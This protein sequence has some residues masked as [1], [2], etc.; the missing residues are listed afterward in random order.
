M[1]VT[2]QALREALTR[3]VPLAGEPGPDG[4]PPQ[5]DAALLRGYL[6]QRRFEVDPFGV[7]LSGFEIVGELAAEATDVV[8]PVGFER[9][10]FSHPL[11]LSGSSLHSLALVGCD[12]P[13]LVGNGLRLRRDLILS[14]SRISGEVATSASISYPGAVW[15][16]E[17]EIG[18]R[19]VAAGTMIAPPTGRAL[20]ADGVRVRGAV[21][22]IQDFAAT[23]EVR[24]LSSRLGSLDISGARFD[25]RDGWALNLT[26]TQLEGNLLLLRDTTG[27]ATRL[28]GWLDL[29]DAHVGGQLIV[30]DASFAVPQRISGSF[31][32]HL[33]DRGH[34]C[35]VAPRLAVD[36]AVVLS[37]QTRLDGGADLSL[38]RMS[39]LRVA[40][41][42]RLSAA[43]SEALDLSRATIHGGVR[44]DRGLQVE[45][46]VAM[47]GARL[48]GDL[49]MAG[50]SLSRPQRQSALRASGIVVDGH[51]DLSGARVEG[52]SVRLTDAT[53][54]GSVDLMGATL[55]HP[56]V[57]PEETSE[58]QTLNL[59]SARVKGSVR[60]GGGFRSTGQVILTRAEVEGWLECSD[61]TFLGPGPNRDNPD[62]DAL[63]AISA[64][65][66]RG[67]YL[68]WR[69]CSPSADLT[70]LETTLVSDD[71]A[72]APARLVLSGFSYDRFTRPRHRADLDPWDPLTRCAWLARQP[73]FD[74]GAYEQA[75]RVFARHGRLPAAETILM[76][77]RDVARDL[78]IVA[79]PW[80]A[81]GTPRWWRQRVRYVTTWWFGRLFGYG[82]RPLR[83]VAGM[84]G[85]LAAVV[86]ALQV[87]AV[88]GVLRAADS[89][90]N[91][92]APD[93]R[94]VT[95]A[96]SDAAVPADPVVLAGRRLSPDPCGGGQVRCFDPVLFA[97]DTVVPLVALDQRAT[98][99]PDPQAP[100]GWLIGEAL[101][102]ATILGW[103]LST[104]LVLSL[105][106]LSRTLPT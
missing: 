28:T 78:L 47:A 48:G 51:V 44:F 38:S 17:A 37:G 68:D 21:R 53:I 91:V 12:L 33:E 104:T 29:E 22:L 20:H 89:R 71:P 94:V 49:A 19:L 61:G 77:Q 52:G 106:R 99:Y 50:V 18:G 83:A 102:V 23:G 43:G 10:S 92:Y 54:A 97:V 14:G 27:Q 25:G 76:T 98:W 69:Q 81:R 34:L 79:R 4:E 42:V 75:A 84:L 60:L 24:L 64:R 101:A 36:G 26:E 5:L 35:V 13:A 73:V 41:T 65:V 1:E 88:A 46:T 45:G 16:C 105:A 8:F 58:G 57:T 70:S 3:G 9:C 7:R 82:F 59:R 39:S 55:H 67:L 95:V 100:W 72:N 31:A 63:T 87:P 80:I 85:L 66:V 30:V 11:Q 2:E 90:G 74:E 62:D 93:G 6:T 86:L 15:L 96:A 56:T 40:S 103:V 32:S